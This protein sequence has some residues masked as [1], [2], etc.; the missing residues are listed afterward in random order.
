[1]NIHII[2]DLGYGDS[3]KGSM[4]DYIIRAGRSD[5]KKFLVIRLQG[6]HQVGHT[7]KFDEPGKTPV[8]HEFRNFGSGTFQG[9]DTWYGPE[10]TMFPLG[11]EAE[12]NELLLKKFKPFNYYH[13]D[14]MVTTSYD[15]A[16]NRWSE[17]SKGIKRHG[18]VGMG[19]NATIERNKKCQFTVG[20]LVNSNQYILQLKLQS[21]KDYY[22]D[23][24]VPSS[25][26]DEVDFAGEIEVYSNVAKSGIFDV[27]ALPK[28]NLYTDLIFEPNQGILLDQKYGMFPHVTRSTTTSAA[29]YEYITKHFKTDYKVIKRYAISRC[30]HTRHGAGPFDQFPIELKNTEMESNKFNSYQHDFKVSKLDLQLLE[31]ALRVNFL[32]HSEI[33]NA[34]IVDHVVFTCFDQLMTQYIECVTRTDDGISEFCLDPTEFTKYLINKLNLDVLRTARFWVS[35]NP[36]MHL[37]ET[38]R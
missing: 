34:R 15:I 19:F 6:G 36:K 1:M 24:G 7:V 13:P 38:C 30:Y 20:M 10:T 16:F 32:E 31:Y 28:H 3:G 17:D 35:I 25:V 18:S 22:R 26:L 11:L 5:S 23:W 37:I 14:V 21:I 2:T 29:A 12:Y 33:E 8:L 4:V 27:R 9:I